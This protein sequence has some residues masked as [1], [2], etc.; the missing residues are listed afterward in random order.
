[1]SMLKLKITTLFFCKGSRKSVCLAA[2]II[3]LWRSLFK[4]NQLRYMLKNNIYII[5]KYNLPTWKQ[6]FSWSLH[7]FS[8]NAKVAF[9]GNI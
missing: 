1:M 3:F 8:K 4:E 9:L 5:L 2:R 7:T 6:I